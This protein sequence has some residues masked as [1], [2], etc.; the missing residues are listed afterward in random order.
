MPPSYDQA[1]VAYKAAWRAYHAA[2]LACDASPN[3][4]ALV[5]PF[6]QAWQDYQTAEWLLD[7]AELRGHNVA[8]LRAWAA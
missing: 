6:M 5:E 4:P 2:D 8:P 1:A 3:D 7:H